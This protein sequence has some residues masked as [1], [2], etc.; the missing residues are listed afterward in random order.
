MSAKKAAKKTA[1][2]TTKTLLVTMGIFK[3]KIATPTRKKAP[4]GYV[5]VEIEGEEI[6]LSRSL[7]K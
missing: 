2:K 3:D 7:L 4:A 6:T 5:V 1:A